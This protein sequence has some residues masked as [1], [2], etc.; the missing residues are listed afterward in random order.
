MPTTTLQRL[1]LFRSDSAHDDA[2]LATGSVDRLLAD[3]ET[4]LERERERRCAVRDEQARSVADALDEAGGSQSRFLHRRQD[5]AG[6][7]GDIDHLAVTPS[8]VWVVGAWQEAG[9]RV[10]VAFANGVCDD[11]RERL[12]VRGRDKTQLVRRLTCQLDAVAAAL[13]SYDVPVRGLL[14]FF[15]AELPRVWEPVIHGHAVGDAER[16]RQ[17]LQAPGP[18]GDRWRTDLHRVLAEAF[19]AV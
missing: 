2:A 19:P 5:P 6:A 3:V 12:L 14:C 1:R 4:S 10:T 17:V 9:A 7:C 16:A 8:G 13:A 18:V 11:D 15:D